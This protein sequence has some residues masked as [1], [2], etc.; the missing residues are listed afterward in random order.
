M[1]DLE[2]RH[3]EARVLARSEHG[4]SR[5]QIS[6]N[7]LK[8]LYRLHHAGFLAFLVGGAVRDILL[9]RKPKD[10]DIG[11]NAR[12]QQVRQLFRNARVIGRRFRLAM[13]RFADE[14][15]EVATFRK[16]PE[17]PEAD[18]GEN[19][20]VLA[21]AAEAEEF[22]TPE[23]DARR[24]DFTVNGLFYNVA[25]FSIVDHVGGL[26]DLARGVIRT[27]G[28]APE[29]FTE[30]PVRMM[31]AVE[32]AARLGF[33]LDDAAADAIAALHAEIR[34][35][36]PA[37]IAY[38]L[39]ESLKS[40]HATAILQGLEGAGLLDHVLPEIAETAR[41]PAG[42]LLWSLLALTD[43]RIA[44]GEAVTEETL[45]GSLLLPRFLAEL[46]GPAGAI[47]PAGEVE[48][49]AKSVVEPPAVRLAFPHH[50]AHLI[51]SA[52][53][54]MARFQQPPR[55]AKHVLRTLKHEAFEVAWRLAADLEAADG[56][57]QLELAP[58]RQAV[59]RVRAG[60]APELAASHSAPTVEGRRRRR[61]GGAR[62]R[63]KKGA[64]PA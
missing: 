53:L 2:P 55:S 12:P 29:R 49:L 39:L 1:A 47:R 17:P 50:R 26:E 41:G 52:F 35:A 36:A 5:A 32:Y 51:R 22:G 48:A 7:A 15:V 64:A 19:A 24:R 61:R 37:R 13:I 43:R 44:A 60:L 18:P 4:L 9:G 46:K 40:G 23:E 57:P 16:S 31:R 62:R 14:T 59:A 25:D 56:A 27:I 3:A 33:R 58:W 54:L 28:P 30:D 45:F 38:E 42:P 6:P 34:R 21:P 8:V 10:F 20:D 11:T 63:R